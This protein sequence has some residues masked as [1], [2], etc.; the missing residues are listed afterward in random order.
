MVHNSGTIILDMMRNIVA[1]VLL[2]Y[3]KVMANYDVGSNV[4]AV[5]ALQTL[6]KVVY[7]NKTS[8]R[9]I[10]CKR[11]DVS[12]GSMLGM[13]S[14]ADTSC[15]GRH[16]RI[17]EQIDG[18]QCTVKPFNDSYKPMENVK[19][20]NGALAYDD[21]H[22][23]TF[24]LLLNQAM[25][26]TATMENS[27]L[28]V[29]QSRYNGVV[30]DDV[31][32]HLDYNG[33]SNQEI[34][35][36]EN[37]VR[38]PL[39]MVNKSVLGISVRYPTDFDLEFGRHLELTSA[40]IWDPE[41]TNDEIY[42]ASIYSQK[43]QIE[44]EVSS[45]CRKITNLH[46]YNISS[47]KSTIGESKHLTKEVLSNMWGITTQSAS[48][49]LK[50]TTRHNIKENVGILNRRY[51]T[52]VHQRAYKQLG[53]DIGRFY[54][55][56]VFSKHKSLRGNTCGQIYCNNFNYQKFYPMTSKSQA[57]DTL[58]LFI[59]QVGVP[60]SLHSDDAKELMF[61]KFNKVC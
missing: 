48:K 21:D 55:D 43:Y 3:N 11:N 32:K 16:V 31:P 12:G 17:L 15:A 6:R 22:G 29:N 36:P 40:S 33:H 10:E 50:A 58:N 25:D 41:S 46:S 35:F 28:S 59:D 14:H 60:S 26:F 53:G 1:V 47:I 5:D 23:N 9:S 51:K 20:I 44:D 45:L 18:I 42:L 19:I 7:S 30:I 52:K 27:L 8:D 34:Y 2:F 54:T 37:D 4:Y 38:I 49:T 39:D 13:D 56:T 61:G 24:I 57:V